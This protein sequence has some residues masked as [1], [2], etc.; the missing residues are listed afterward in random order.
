MCW[1]PS[2]Q[3]FTWTDRSVCICQTRPEVAFNYTDPASTTVIHWQTL[4]QEPRAKELPGLFNKRSLRYLRTFVW[5]FIVVSFVNREAVNVFPVTFFAKKKKKEKL[6]QRYFA[7]IL[8]YERHYF[9][10][11]GTCFT[12]FI[13]QMIR[14]FYSYYAVLPSL[15]IAPM[16]SIHQHRISV[17]APHGS[18]AT[19]CRNVRIRVLKSISFT[20]QP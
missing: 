1:A 12:L 14:V 7:V 13:L 5:F 8:C 6:P 11:V 4:Y 9:R 3:C 16:Q 17:L 15:V 2:A 18:L 19:N 10:M 20:E